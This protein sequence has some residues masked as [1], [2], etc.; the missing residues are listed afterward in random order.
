MLEVTVDLLRHGEPLGG[1]KFRGHGI[2]DPLNDLGWRQMRAAV[3]GYAGW[4]QLISSPMERCR[5]FA[6]E[7]ATERSLPLAIEPNLREVGFGAWEGLTPAELRVQDAAAYER[8]YQDPEQHRPA[9]AESL[10]HF[11]QRVVSAYTQTINGHPGRHLLVVAHAGVIRAIIGHVLQS[12]LQ[13][14]YRISIDYASLSRIRYTR[15]GTKLVFANRVAQDTGQ[16][17]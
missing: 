8:F 9:R 1:S 13:C 16:H 6:A 10:E 12:P 5:C 15:Y 2:N 4:Q 11:R 7:L 3:R 17:S 14:W